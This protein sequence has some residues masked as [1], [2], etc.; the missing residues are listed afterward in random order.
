MF[1][2][3]L[4]FSLFIAMALASCQEPKIAT[5]WM[6]GDSTMADYANYGEDYMRDRYPMTG[7]GQALPGFLAPDSLAGIPLF[8]LDSISVQ[9]KARGG[10]STRSFFEEGRWAEV[11]NQ[12]QPG[13]FVIIQFG[14]NDASVSKGERYVSIPGYK[15]FLRLYVNQTRQQGATPILI[16]SVCRNYPWEN[17]LLGNSH[18]DYPQAMREVAEELS[19]YLIDLTE[20][21][22][23]HF[24]KMN[25]EY[26]T[27]NYFMNLPAGK[28]EAYPE[29]LTDN[30]HF[31]P[32]GAREV[33][34]LVVDCLKTLE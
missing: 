17:D 12:L 27:V 26:V 24:T 10:R 2:L 8:Q 25:R 16:T 9:N 21:S 29:G 20:I 3:R 32:E 15:E 6:I 31:Q 34:R 23:Q 19:V 22:A 28:F 33:S 1:N 5:L 4:F 7:W 14:H 18:G 13:D 30:T 11:Y